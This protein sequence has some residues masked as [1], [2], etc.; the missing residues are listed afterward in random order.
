[1]ATYEGVIDVLV[2]I[3]ESGDTKITESGDTKIAEQGVGPESV[4]VSDEILVS[5]VA[6]ASVNESVAVSDEFVV[7]KII[8]AV[9]QESI[10]VN[11]SVD[12][13]WVVEGV[14]NEEYREDLSLDESIKLAVKCLTR[15]LEVRGEPKRIKINIIPIETQKLQALSGEKIEAIQRGLEGSGTK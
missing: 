15:A 1:M 13:N 12:V 2:K 10:S 14:L 7:V 3:T 9:L 4:L 5:W 8:D 6:A 11:D